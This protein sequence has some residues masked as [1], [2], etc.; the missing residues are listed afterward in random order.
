[1]KKPSLK[2][3]DQVIIQANVPTKNNTLYSKEVCEEMIRQINEKNPH[4]ILGELVPP[5]FNS[6][7]ASFRLMAEVDF[8]NVALKVDSAE[9]DG[10]KVVADITILEGTPKG[11]ILANLL[12]EMEEGSIIFRPKAI[13]NYKERADDIKEIDEMK[14][15]SI[16]ALPKEQDSLQ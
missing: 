8:N 2:L 9:M 15:I 14:L 7:D 3:K 4:E 10:D 13:V 5:L 6:D 12:K 16:S 11:D 1:M